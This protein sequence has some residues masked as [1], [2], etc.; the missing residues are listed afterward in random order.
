MTSLTRLYKWP[1]S[2]HCLTFTF[3]S[4]GGRLEFTSVNLFYCPLTLEKFANE[5]E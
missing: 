5:G 4:E 1:E 2:M 3:G